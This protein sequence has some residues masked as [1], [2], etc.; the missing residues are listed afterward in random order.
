M[1]ISETHIAQILREYDSMRSA[2][3][4]QALQ[5]RQQLYRHI[6]RIK[7]IDRELEAFGLRAV[8]TYLRTGTDKALV[9]SELKQQN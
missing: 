1:S 8:Q 4:A 3:E 9:I 2:A 6:P 7:A 5:R